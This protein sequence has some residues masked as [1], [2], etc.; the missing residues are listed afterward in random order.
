MITVEVV[1]LDAVDRGGE[2][3]ASQVGAAI[4]KAEETECLADL[5]LVEAVEREPASGWEGEL[6]PARSVIRGGIRSSLTRHAAGRAEEVHFSYSSSR[7][8]GILAGS[9]ERRGAAHMGPSVDTVEV[10]IQ[11]PEGEPSNRVARWALALLTT[12]ISRHPPTYGRVT[13][14]GGET[15]WET[16]QHRSRPRSEFYAVSDQ[17]ILN[18][19]W[20][21]F[22]TKRHLEQL[23]IAR[24]ATL[25]ARVECMTGGVLIQ[26]TPELF[27]MRETDLEEWVSLLRPILW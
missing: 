17:R 18:P 21:F 9:V 7:A 22:V 24:I 10:T 15:W 5:V 27:D 20:A 2:I 26:R 11:D 23:D 12:W 1:Y 13:M 3:G 16:T 19:D 6:G 25:G 4:E 8:A 14:G